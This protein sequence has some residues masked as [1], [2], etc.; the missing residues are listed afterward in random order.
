MNV[1]PPTCQLDTSV[2]S[3]SMEDE[4]KHIDKKWSEEEMKLE[5]EHFKKIVNAFLYYK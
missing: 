2:S 1:T 3:K 4:V 5:K